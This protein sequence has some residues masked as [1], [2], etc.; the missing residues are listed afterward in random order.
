[1]IEA[2]G[3][4]CGVGVPGERYTRV[5]RS[6]ARCGSR[7][8]SSSERLWRAEGV[9]GQRHC[10]RS[11]VP[12]EFRCGHIRLRTRAK[13]GRQRYGSVTPVLWNC[14]VASEGRFWLPVCTE[15]KSSKI[16]HFA[17]FSAAGAATLP[18]RAACN[19]RNVGVR[20]AKT[21]PGARRGGCRPGDAGNAKGRPR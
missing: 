17:R 1:M 4:V 6:R 5:R 21:V 12:S 19:V 8:R 11:C 7:A 14:K 9:A 20:N 15:A 13:F 2:D 3:R 18:L 10:T 16:L